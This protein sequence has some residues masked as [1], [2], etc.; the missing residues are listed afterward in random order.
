MPTTAGTLHLSDLQTY[1]KR[2]FGDESGVQITDADIARWVNIG[3]MEIVTKN[4]FNEAILDTPSVIGQQAYSLPTDLIEMLS[5]EYDS[6]YMLTST[7]FEGMK[8][9]L[10]TNQ[11]QRGIPQF[12]YKFA[13][14]LFLW[15][16][17]SAIKTIRIYYIQAPSRI[18]SPS[19][20]LPIPDRYYDQLCAFVMSKAYELDEDLPSAAAQRQMFEEKLKE[21]SGIENNMEGSFPVVKDDVYGGYYHGRGFG[22]YNN[23]IDYGGW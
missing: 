14:Q 13:N 20:L 16:V 2:Q 7:S 10:S 4:P 1:V 21:K 12:W 9:I 19:D 22:T 11:T 8:E 18:S 6:T 5:V 23:D 3:T 15:P 17:P